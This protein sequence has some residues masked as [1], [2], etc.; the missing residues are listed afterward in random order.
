MYQFNTSCSECILLQNE[1]AL[2]AESYYD[3]SDVLQ[4]K[5]E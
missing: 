2:I 4:E 5:K 1:D 3:G